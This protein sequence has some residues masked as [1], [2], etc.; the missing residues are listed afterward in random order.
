MH[1]PVIDSHNGNSLPLRLQLKHFIKTDNSIEI[2]ILSD[3]LILSYTPTQGKS[4]SFVLKSGKQQLSLITSNS[5]VKTDNGGI[6]YKMYL[7]NPNAQWTNI[8]LLTKPVPTLAPNQIQKLFLLADETQNLGMI[9]L[10]WKLNSIDESN[11][12]WLLMTDNDSY[13]AKLDLVP[14]EK[15]E[16]SKFNISLALGLSRDTILLI[17][18]SVCKLIELI[19]QK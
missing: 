6:S 14:S 3:K 4:N 7:S 8:E 1:L 5:P 15:C 18:T 13:I 9:S 11:I 12:S 17:L 16:S 19:L 2:S 10:Y